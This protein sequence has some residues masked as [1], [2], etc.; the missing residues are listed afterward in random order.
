[1]NGKVG[2]LIGQ[3]SLINKKKKKN[4]SSIGFWLN[5]PVFGI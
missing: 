4:C 3:L 2:P 1:M 5:K